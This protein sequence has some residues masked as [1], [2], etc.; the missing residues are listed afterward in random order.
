MNYMKLLKKTAW[1]PVIFLLVSSSCNKNKTFSQPDQSNQSSPPAQVSD[2][3]LKALPKDLGGTHTPVVLNATDN[4]IY[5]YYLYKPY[6]YDAST[7]YY[8]LLIS[9]TGGGVEGNSMTNPSDLNKI[10]GGGIQ[11]MIKNNAWAPKPA[12]PRYPMLVITPQIT[13][14]MQS[15][16]PDNLHAFIKSV[17]SKYR[18]NI[19]RIYMT[20]LSTGG[21]DAFKYVQ[22]YP[23]G[24]VAAIVPTAGVGPS[25]NFPAY[26]NF[27]IWAFV[28]QNDTKKYI[29]L[30]PHIDSINKYST[31]IKAKITVY[32]GVGHN[33]WDM[34]Y[35]GSGM[36][37]EDP[38]F[39]PF[40]M[41]VYDWMFQY[42]K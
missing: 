33:C 4:T 35:N 6:G 42:A 19:H 37:S 39:D 24:Y 11:S 41:S 27:P 2:A 34:T 28:G 23:N 29:S 21:S 18:V 25:T 38:N 13:S 15:Y 9:L 8:P 26:K 16:S 31:T 7:S 3:D 30:L 1:I 22:Y 36:G 20:G 17:I 14:P 10:L 5:G 40:N 32:P 12:A